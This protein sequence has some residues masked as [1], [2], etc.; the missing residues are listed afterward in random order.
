MTT[1]LI[2]IE[3]DTLFS[4]LE[5]TPSI[6]NKIFMAISQRI[7]FTY[8]RLESRVYTRP[9]TRIYAFLENKLLE[10]RI[11]LKSTNPVTLNF[12]IDELI[13]MTGVSASSPGA[14]MDLAVTIQISASILARSLS[15]TRVFFPQKRDFTDRATTSP[16][17]AMKNEPHTGNTIRSA[18]GGTGP[19]Q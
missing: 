4:L 5:K 19:A 8:I 10:D 18:A 3:K 16:S 9:I 6:I 13:R 17:P 7:W 14:P 15:T 2:A 1:T 12:G 11:S